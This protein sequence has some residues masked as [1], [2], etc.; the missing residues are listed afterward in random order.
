MARG[1]SPTS[2]N[3]FALLRG[4]ALLRFSKATQASR[5]LRQTTRTVTKESSAGAFS[6]THPAHLHPHACRAREHLSLE[7]ALTPE[8]VIR[9]PI[10]FN[11]GS[12]QS[13]DTHA[14]A[15]AESREAGTL[16]PGCSGSQR[17]CLVSPRPSQPS[18]HP[19]PPTPSAR[20][21]QGRAPAK[22]STWSLGEEEGQVA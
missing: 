20:P 3:A 22:P 18:S 10:N 9:P 19:P 21:G 14:W 5:Q 8:L 11:A 16:H 12:R 6:W 7:K 13:G 4:G 15:G 2:T 17:L 1:P